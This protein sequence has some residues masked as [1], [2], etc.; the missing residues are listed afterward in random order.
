MKL[1]FRF[2]IPKTSTS[3]AFI[4]D[5]C[6]SKTGKAYENSL[7][8]RP[9]SPQEC[10]LTVDQ[11]AMP[12]YSVIPMFSSQL[13]QSFTKMAGELPVLGLTLRRIAREGGVEVTLHRRWIRRADDRC[14]T[15]IR[16]SVNGAGITPAIGTPS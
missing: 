7:I 13:C 3:D 9:S 15:W 6:C 12:Q 11:W 16:R 8:M 1:S 2:Q 4:Y 5:L 14:I 10:S